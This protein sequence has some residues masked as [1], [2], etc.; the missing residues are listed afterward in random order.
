MTEPS[1]L[2]KRWVVLISSQIY[3][4]G[5]QKLHGMGAKKNAGLGPAFYFFQGFIPCKSQIFS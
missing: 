3:F 2:G 5:G 1:S 4:Q